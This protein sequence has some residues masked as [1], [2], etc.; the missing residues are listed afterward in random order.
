MAKNLG[1]LIIHGMGDPD[2]TFAAGLIKNLKRRLGR[3][4]A[5][6]AFTSCYWSPILQDHQDLMWQRLL[7]SGT[8]DAKGI[9]KWVVSALGDPALYL[10]GYFKNGQPIYADIH[11]CV[12]TSL[13]ELEAQLD[14]TS[15]KPL[16]VLAHSLGSVIM[17]NYIWDEQTEQGIGRTAFE[18]MD[19][20]TS[21]ITYGSTIPIFIPPVQ[22]VTCI[23][24]P[25]PELPEQ[26]ATIA[27]WLNIF[28]PD[29]VLGYPLNDIWTE[30]QGTVIR[31]L[32]INAGL[33]PASETPLAHSLYHQDDDF[34]AIVLEQIRAILA[35]Q[36]VE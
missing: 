5:D 13:T 3:V 17:S 29:D 30:R 27:Q 16:M 19:T 14:E 34:L 28:D 2:E 22:N 32:P 15:G 11:Q 35:A 9:R 10:S 6:V 12:C 21:L 36:R 8:M 18:K 33:W 26:F 4:E 24:F 31:D 23:K 20:L 25:P 7:R 1:I